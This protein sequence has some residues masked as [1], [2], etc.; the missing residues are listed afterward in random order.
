[1][2][3]DAGKGIITY[4]SSKIQGPKATQTRGCYCQKIRTST[5]FPQKIALTPTDRKRL[6]LQPR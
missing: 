1:M 5:V 6:H 2:A 3:S 4:L